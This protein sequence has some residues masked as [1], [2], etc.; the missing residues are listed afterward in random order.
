M[1]RTNIFG[2]LIGVLLEM[3]VEIV[4]ILFFSRNQAQSDPS[5]NLNIF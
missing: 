5:H 3:L 2:I 4:I 1:F